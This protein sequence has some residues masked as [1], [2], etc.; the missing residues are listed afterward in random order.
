MAQHP[1]PMRT[2]DFDYTLPPEL[3]AQTPMEPRDQSRLLVLDRSTGT[4]THRALF[5]AIADFL[6]Q[7]DL[8]VL[9]DT[10]VL[11]ARLRGT[12]APQGA[13]VELL[14]LRRLAPSLWR[15]MGRPGRR[16]RPGARLRFEGGGAVLEAS[17]L[18]VDA[19]GYRVVR[20]DGEEKLDLAGEAPLPPY[21]HTPL[22]DPERYQT[23]YARASGSAA[24]PTAG[25]HFTPSLLERLAAQGV[26]SAYVTLHIGPGTFRPVRAE[27]PRE[28]VLDAE[29]FEL[30][31][32]AAAAINRAKADGRRVVCVG[33]T[34]VRLL[35]TVAARLPAGAPLAPGAGWA[36]LLVLPG[37]DFRVPD[38]LVTNF[39]LPRS[40][41]L[42]LVAAFAGR[43]P[44]LRAY[45]EAVERGYRFASFGDCMLI[46]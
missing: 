1:H 5:T 10:R 15:C 29:F 42:M 37:H 36:D 16:L 45:R 46:A 44:V 26:E 23:V 18:E 13:D 6:R 24:A 19:E 38:V 14:L 3:I 8:L 43:V 27:D 9:N 25:L 7:G 35:E 17:V 32:E 4:I 33:T 41:L 39:H 31:A 11:P 34:A 30:G 40:T 12:T 2:S 20:L 28:H 21:I 22:A